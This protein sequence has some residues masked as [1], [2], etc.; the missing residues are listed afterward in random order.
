MSAKGEKPSPWVAMLVP[1]P[2]FTP[3]HPGHLAPYLLKGERQLARDLDRRIWS[4]GPL[5]KGR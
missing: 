3:H 5:L 2:R 4:M 1:R